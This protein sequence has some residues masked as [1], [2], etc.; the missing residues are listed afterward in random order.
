[1]MSWEELTQT[2]FSLPI[3]L[4]RDFALL[5]DLNEK[6]GRPHTSFR[7]IHVAGTNGKGSVSWKIARALESEG[8]R[9]GLYTSPH[10]FDVRERI[11]IN[12]AMISKNEALS[13]LEPLL[14]KYSLYSFFE[15]LT[16]AAFLYFQKQQVDWAVIE[17]GLGGRFDATN[18][19]FPE[20]AAITSIGL[21]HI[22]ILGNTLEEIAWEKGGIIKP[23]IPVVAG[24]T[25]S[26]F[27][28]NSIAVSPQPFF[29]LENQAVARAVLERLGISKSSIALGLAT[30]PPCRF[31]R[32]GNL[33]LDVAH[34]PDGFKKLIEALQLHFPGEKFHFIVG[35]SKDKDWKQ[36]LDLISPFARS[37]T[38]VQLNKERLESPKIL[39][40]YCPSLAI[41]PS[42]H[43]AMRLGEE[44]TVVCGS[45]Y[46]MGESRKEREPI[47]D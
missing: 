42:I 33:I 38:A 17:V 13:I 4:R 30:R 20:I 36:C 15:I 1:M 5:K 34:N 3:R 9:V 25:A 23:G 27:F 44:M 45:F 16:F 7:S 37:I 46:L 28:L 32:R 19:I 35:F 12:G 6:L 21:D 26:R 47:F 18:V 2:L 14:K 10:I 11:Q 40:A 41:A 29:D 43:A 24:P 8:F 31:E 39:Q 22:P